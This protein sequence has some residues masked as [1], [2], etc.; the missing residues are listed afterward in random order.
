LASRSRKFDAV[1]VVA[2]TGWS[3]W[4]VV[5]GLGWVLASGGF[6]GFSAWLF[7]GGLAAVAGGNVVFLSGVA[8]R[9]FRGASKPLVAW[10]ELLSCVIFFC[11]LLLSLLGLL[12]PRCFF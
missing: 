1:V 11:G 6:P 7:A 8:D 5:G 2:A 4:L 3:V 9:A 10:L 12:L